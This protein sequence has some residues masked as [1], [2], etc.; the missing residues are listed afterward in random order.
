[1]AVEAPAATAV[2]EP[3]G[4]VRAWLRSDMRVLRWV[5]LGIYALVVLAPLGL[6]VY[7]P[8]AAIPFLIMGGILIAAQ[9][10]FIF[11]A[12]T[13]QLCRPIKKRRLVA[14]V[15]VAALM[16]TL[17]VVGLLIAL[18]ELFRID[19]TVDEDLFVIAFWGFIALSWIGWGVLI[20]SYAKDRP[21]F[22][23]LSRISAALFAGSL[24]ELL[25]T[26]PSH[27]IVIRRPGC[28]VGVGTMLGIVAGLNVMFF[29]FGPMVLLL[30]LRPRYRRERAMGSQFC[31][32]C[33]YDLRASP[34]RCPEC[35][36]PRRAAATVA[37]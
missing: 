28:L 19:E 18:S 35:G 26:V 12:G 32:V 10:L 29:S 1:M 24:L 2:H 22:A 31:E 23:V 20:F 9:A 11:G 33:G 4:P 13:I 34:V 3:L 25:A 5:L 37:P 14:P 6:L 30:F 7:E 16:F 36:R 27:M 21:R 8:D 15:I 17:L